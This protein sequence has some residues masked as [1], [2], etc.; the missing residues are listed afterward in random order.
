MN[1]Q[2]LEAKI[3]ELNQIENIF[4]Y[5]EA[6]SQF[7]SEYKQS[8]F[9]KHTKMPLKDIMK[10]SK[11]FYMFNLKNIFAAIQNGINTLNLDNISQ[12]L[13]Q[14]NEVFG[15]ENNSILSAIQSLKDLK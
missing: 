13:N 1:N 6:I 10:Y 14:V 8:D 12:L 3:L 4:D 9:Y 11:V 7:S 2:E 15:E 5:I